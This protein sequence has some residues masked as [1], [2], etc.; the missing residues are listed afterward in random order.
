MNY[1]KLI[2]KG[3]HVIR[4]TTKGRYALRAMLDLT[5]HQGINS[6]VTR[7]DIARRQGLPATYLAQL[8]AALTK[9]GLV[10]SVRG[11]GGGYLLRRPAEQITVGEVIR[12][13]EGPVIPVRCVVDRS[14]VRASRCS[15]RE[16]YRG[17]GRVIEQYL[18]AVPLS[19]LSIEQC[20]GEAR[21]SEYES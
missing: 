20:Q 1:C 2:N 18:D 7:E 15:L 8:F 14:C 19:Q 9:A 13:V 21:P 6:P 10:E 12:A 11:P 16:L 4:I 17:L 5:V 3:G